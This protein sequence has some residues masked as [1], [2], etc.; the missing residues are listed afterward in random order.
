[1]NKKSLAL[2]ILVAVAGV[3]GL[4]YAAVTTVLMPMDLNEF[5]NQLNSASE[6]SIATN[7]SVAQSESSVA[8]M[9]TYS[10]LNY[11]SQSQRTKM[12][13]QM[14]VNATIPPDA[15]NFTEYTRYNNYKALAYSLALKGDVSNQIQNVTSTYNEINNLS[16]QM[17]SLN[18]KMSADFENGD[19][20]AYADD[21]RNIT[22]LTKQVN[23]KIAL[24]KTQLQ[25]VINQLSG[26]NR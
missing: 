26:S 9:E 2:I 19:N 14:R 7:S 1:M 15:L 5:K 17:I 20:K 4:F 25:T 18:Q 21:L 23:T 6:C 10:P 8:I 22:S 24:L 16:S 11:L 13:G 12:A 3:Y